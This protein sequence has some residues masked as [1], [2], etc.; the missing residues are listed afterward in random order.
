MNIDTIDQAIEKYVN[1]RM[2]KGRK[3]ATE[4]FLAYAYLKHGSGEVV[5]FMKRVRGL[6]RYYIDFLNVMENPFRG[7]ELAFFASMVV[8]ACLGG[9]LTTQEDSRLLG[10]LILSG[11]LVHAWSLLCTVA[12]KWLDLGVMVAIYREIIELADGELQAAA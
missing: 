4:K 7:P 10:I 2:K 1:E 8:V 5:E 3:C 11:T 12:R 6:T 9:Y